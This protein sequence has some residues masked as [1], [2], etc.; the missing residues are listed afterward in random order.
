MATKKY[1]IVMGS[2]V[3]FSFYFKNKETGKALT[4]MNT[5][6]SATL[7]LRKEDNTLLSVSGTLISED[8]AQVDF[9]ISDSDS[10]LLKE[11]PDQDFHVELVRGSDTQKVLFEK[12]LTVKAPLV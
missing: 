4:G 5:F 10:A 11:G 2:D 1:T 3:T 9:T 6:T 7:K 8:L 12:R